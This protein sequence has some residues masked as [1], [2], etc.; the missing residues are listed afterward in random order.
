MSFLKEAAGQE[1][2]DQARGG[3][4]VSLLVQGA[5]GRSLSAGSPVLG[6][7][8]CSMSITIMGV[9]GAGRGAA[10][11][12][13]VDEDQG[14]LQFDHVELS[15]NQTRDGEQPAFLLDPRVSDLLASA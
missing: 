1:S 7:P 12:N 15:M 11:R 14:S 3:V 6:R 10:A 5:G 4:G 13:F 9:G 2:L 8:L